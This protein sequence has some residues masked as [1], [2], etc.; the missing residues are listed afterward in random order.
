M[1]HYLLLFSLLISGLI[2]IPLNATDVS[3][4]QSGTWTLVNS[5]YNII[6]DVTVPVGSSLT[7]EPGV[8]IYA[9]G[10]YYLTVQGTL[11]AIGTEADTIRFKSGQADPDALWKGIRLENESLPSSISY[12]FIEKAEYGVNSVNSPVQITHNRFSHNQKALQIFAI[13]AA[14][15][16]DVLI[17]ENI[18]E[19]SIHNGIMI[20]QNS[21]LVIENNEIRSNGTGTQ[22][23]AAIQLSNQSSDGSNSPLIQN[24]HIHHNFK[25]GITAWDLVGVN[26]IQPQILNNIIE[27]NLTGI[28]LLNSS[29]YIAD[30]IIRN[31]F[32]PGDANSG[33]GVMITGA[34][35]E[36]YFERNQI[37]GNFT[38]FYL[39]QNAKPCLGNLSI[40]H[41]W[42]QGENAIY[43]NIDETN[44]L[45]SIYT[46]SYTDP[47]IVIFA[48]NNYWGTTNPAEIAAGILDHNDN[49]SLP[50]VDFDPFLLTYNATTVSGQIT[51]SGN[52]TLINHRLQIIGADSGDILAEEF[53]N[54]E[55]PFSYSS[56]LSEPFYV[57]VLANIADIDQTFYGTP[58][59]LSQPQIFNPNPNNT[60]NVGNIE[61]SET[62]PPIYQTIGTPTMIGT[63]NCYPLYHRFFVYHWYYINWLYEEGDYLYLARHERYN[64][65]GNIIFNLPEETVWDKIHNLNTGDSWTRTEIIDEEG[66][67]RQ[68][69]FQFRDVTEIGCIVDKSSPRDYFYSIIIQKDNA[70]QAI[71]TVKLLLSESDINRLYTYNEDG[72]AKRVDDISTNA[73]TPYL[74]EGNWW[75][76][77]PIV[78]IYQPQWLCYDLEAFYEQ[79][80][81]LYWQPPMADGIHQWT[82]YRIYNSYNQEIPQMIAEV[83]FS[84]TY[85]QRN[86]SFNEHYILTVCAFDGNTESLPTNLIVVNPTA[87]N[88]PVATPPVL[89]I[90][91]NPA[92]FSVNQQVEIA[93]KSD[94]NL[95][96][97][98]NIYNIRG[99]V[100]KTIPLNAKGEFTYRWDGKDNKGTQCSSG[101][102]FVKVK[103][104]GL[105]NLQHKLVLMK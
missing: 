48:E 104:K 39:G 14:D 20:N 50:T 16:A 36:P 76:F 7:I 53:I 44:T 8:N 21:D 90:H 51:Y 34:T 68:T 25:Q 28:Y 47:S 65:S 69:S 18:I 61:I 12:C 66:T 99:Q 42:A 101:I 11:N 13:G 19:W 88:D 98:I 33:A 9:M 73:E 71:L 94:V 52:F 43:N 72:Y 6:G 79:S 86:I 97:K 1:K 64:P 82:S 56:Q 45:H 84:Q 55:T 80:L 41:I 74:Q 40:Y 105:S 5:P 93:I 29:G 87:Y 103:S 89:S 4:N 22:Y 59:G 57:V 24:N 46:Y 26:A 77:D 91:P 60:V 83:P 100:V 32:I 38:G 85:W 23:Y 30:N 70:T 75:E 102:Y 78:P 3:G 2:L 17:S 67:Q 37:Y 31:N 35:S 96:G 27:N 95:K 81:N 63:H 10:N 49:P 92:C 62:L 15:P 54:P 58:G